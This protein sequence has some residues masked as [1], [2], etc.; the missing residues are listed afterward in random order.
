MPTETESPAETRAEATGSE[1][2]DPVPAEREEDIADQAAAPQ[3]GVIAAARALFPG[4]EI[5]GLDAVSPDE[6]VYAVADPRGGKV[7]TLHVFRAPRT[8]GESESVGSVAEKLSTLRAPGIAPL[9]HCE[10]RGGHPCFAFARPAGG[11][12][13]A[14]LLARD[15]VTPTM[16]LRLMV[17]VSRGLDVAH[18]AGLNHHAL[19]PGLI[20]VA[21]NG[22]A[23]VNRTGFAGVFA[24]DQAAVATAF[25]TAPAEARAYLAPELLDPEGEP[26]HRA[27]LFAI[28]AILRRCLT[29]DSPGGPADGTGLACGLDPRID[30]VIGVCLD[31][32]PERRCSDAA[33]LAEAL[34]NIGT[35][36]RFGRLRPLPGEK[37]RPGL[38][39][40]G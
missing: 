34:S 3:Q 17:Q 16:A 28:G 22:P 39:G 14:E 1:E 25:A 27:D 10:V 19:H 5:L 18:G 23:T 21:P 4:L 8:L 33:L 32:D 29:G 20:H 7:F 31:P 38:R 6:A 30:G 11:E 40:V 15:A 9:I 26:D 36:R 35:V 24:V 13:L 37:P 12:S 2:V